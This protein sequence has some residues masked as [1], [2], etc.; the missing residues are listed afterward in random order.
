[1][2]KKNFKRRE[3][4]LREAQKPIV[5]P[6]VTLCVPEP[7][8]DPNDYRFVAVNA[9]T[10]TRINY[11]VLLYRYNVPF[12]DFLSGKYGYADTTNI[13][14]PKFILVARHQS[15]IFS[16]FDIEMKKWNLLDGDE[17]QKVMRVINNL[18][19][20]KMPT[21]SDEEGHIS[22]L[23]SAPSYARTWLGRRYARPVLRNSG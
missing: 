14:D 15:G 6:V 20:A 22:T 3:K 4:A 7:L 5:E 1:M 13:P 17:R 23:C 12:A 16:P 19:M 10:G 2:G 8:Q 18:S 11:D 9:A 21:L